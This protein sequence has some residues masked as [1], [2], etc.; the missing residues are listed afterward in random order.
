MYAQPLKSKS[1]SS[2]KNG[3]TTIFQDLNM[4]VRLILTDSGREF[5]NRNLQDLFKQL[6]IR[7]ATVEIE[8]HNALGII[9]R[10]SR[11]VKEQI[12]RDFTEN[13]TVVWYDELHEYMQA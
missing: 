5:M 2:V 8:D 1:K 4:P 10:F 6:K 13:T 12:F 3:F 11:T 9:D 7:H